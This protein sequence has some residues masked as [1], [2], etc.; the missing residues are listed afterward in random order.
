MGHA[1]KYLTITSKRTAIKARRIHSSQTEEY[2]LSLDHISQLIPFHYRARSLKSI[3]NHTYYK[4]HHGRQGSATPYLPKLPPQLVLQA[5]IPLPNPNSYFFAQA[6][7]SADNLDESD[8]WR[9]DLEPPYIASPSDVLSEEYT[10]NLI[11]VMHGRRLRQQQERDQARGAELVGMSHRERREAIL[12]ELKA[13]LESWQRLDSFLPE[14]RGS[15]REV[16]MAKHLMRWRA[17]T[18]CHLKELWEG[19]Q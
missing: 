3:Q 12:V 2:Y 8:L 4:K 10:E 9:W 19:I 7:S 6:L 11:E 16:F 5:S 14:Y 13:V 15:V 17:R 1:A 18:V